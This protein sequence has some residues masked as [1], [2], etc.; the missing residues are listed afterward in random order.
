[1]KLLLKIQLILYE[2]KINTYNQIII[3]ISLYLILYIIVQNFTLSDINSTHI[4]TGK[5][6][7]LLKFKE[8]INP[9]NTFVRV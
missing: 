9:H 4:S 5:K 3:M 1:M 8:G 7:L 6:L 2:I